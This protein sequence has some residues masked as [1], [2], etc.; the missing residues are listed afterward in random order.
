MVP[1]RSGSLRR[2]PSAKSFSA[3]SRGTVRTVTGRSLGDDLVG[4]SL[5]ALETVVGDGTGGEI[6][7]GGGLAEME[8]DG[9]GFEFTGEDGRKKMLSGVLL[10][11]VEAAGP[12]DRAVNFCAGGQRFASEVPD[13][14]RFIFF[15]GFDGHFKDR[16]VA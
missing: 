9:R 1:S 14:A 2:A 3:S 5:D 8:G 12:V 10:D 16:S 11:V 4:D 7:G 6:D 13:V 15:D